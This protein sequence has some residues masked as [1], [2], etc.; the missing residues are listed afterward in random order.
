MEICPRCDSKNYVKAGFVA[1]RQRYRCKSCNYNFTVEERGVSV[2]K[3][4]LAM[5]LYLE[6][7]SIRRIARVLEVSD[8]AVRKW[9][10][11]WRDDLNFFRNKNANIKPMHKV[12]HFLRS[13]DVFSRFGW[14]MLGIEEN[15]GICLFGS[16]DTGNCEI[17]ND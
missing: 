4:R 17:L 3:K 6:G 14:L 12:E 7:L 5:H 1:K 16:H 15:Q 9:L 8:T 10:L 2:G 11:P 13:R